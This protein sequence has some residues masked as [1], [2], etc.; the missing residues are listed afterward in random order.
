MKVYLLFHSKSEY[1][2]AINILNQNSF[3][4]FE[5]CAKYFPLYKISFNIYSNSK[6]YYRQFLGILP[7]IYSTIHNLKYPT[8]F[9]SKYTDKQIYL[10][11]TKF[12][13]LRYFFGKYKYMLF[14][15]IAL[16]VAFWISVNCSISNSLH[17][18]SLLTDYSI[19]VFP[20][21]GVWKLDFS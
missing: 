11:Y 21:Q 18:V 1:R 17:N 6:F 8:H 9:I 19:K 13:T 15:F 16:S 12:L 20:P 10:I 5:C 14:L 4:Y 7:R 3:K 2:K